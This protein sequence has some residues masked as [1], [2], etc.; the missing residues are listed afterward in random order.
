VISA[1]T[2][3]G[4]CSYDLTIV[5]KRKIA[6]DVYTDLPPEVKYNA[7]TQEVTVAKCHP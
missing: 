7:G 1:I 4:G 5:P 3:T 2:V 6:T